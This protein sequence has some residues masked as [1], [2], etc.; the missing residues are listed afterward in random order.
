V[1]LRRKKSKAMLTSRIEK[2][3]ME[4]LDRLA[5]FK[6]STRTDEVRKYLK[7]GIEKERKKISIGYVSF[8]L[9][10]IAISLT[11]LYVYLVI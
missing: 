5:K 1:K 8:I 6:G 7:D 2:E 3:L 11:S 9:F 10:T 4:D